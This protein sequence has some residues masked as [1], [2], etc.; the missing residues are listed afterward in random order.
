MWTSP[1]E[2]GTET[3][4]Q[5]APASSL[6]ITELVSRSPDHRSP[7]AATQRKTGSSRRPDGSTVTGWR[8]KTPPSKST[9]EGPHVFP[10]S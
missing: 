6:T 4:R 8:T 7:G 2:S 3:S 9:R 1:V 5:F 10:S